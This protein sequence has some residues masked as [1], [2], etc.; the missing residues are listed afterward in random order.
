MNIKSSVI[1]SPELLTLKDENDV[2]GLFVSLRG[3]L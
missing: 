1:E 3:T 2:E